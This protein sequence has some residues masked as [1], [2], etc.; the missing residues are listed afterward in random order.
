MIFCEGLSDANRREVD[1]SYG[2]ILWT[3]LSLVD[4]SYGKI[5]W[6]SLSLKLG[7]C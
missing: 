3:S 5:L 1:L 6:T 2:K 4:L 7:N